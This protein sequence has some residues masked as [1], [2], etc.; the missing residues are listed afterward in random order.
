MELLIYDDFKIFFFF[1]N[2]QGET[3]AI[4]API[5]PYYETYNPNWHN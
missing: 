3:F 2:I 5:I 1:R 4:F